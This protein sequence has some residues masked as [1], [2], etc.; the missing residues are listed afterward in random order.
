[1]SIYSPFIFVALSLYL[2]AYFAIPCKLFISI[3]IIIIIIIFRHS[4]NL[5]NVYRIS[6]HNNDVPFYKTAVLRG[7]MIKAIILLNKL[8]RQCLFQFAKIKNRNGNLYALIYN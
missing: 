4:N 7:W 2:L 1:M 5:K 6:P 8:K 3:I